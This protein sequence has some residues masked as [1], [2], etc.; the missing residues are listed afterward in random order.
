LRI[1]VPIL[2]RDDLAAN[3][4][5]KFDVALLERRLKH[6]GERLTVRIVRSSIVIA[7]NLGAVD[8]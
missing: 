3:A 1:P 8:K 2:S 4:A 5:Q 7:F 6:D